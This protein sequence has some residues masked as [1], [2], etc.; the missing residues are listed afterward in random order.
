M[1]S[2]PFLKSIGMQ[3]NTKPAQLNTRF[4]K[5]LS[6]EQQERVE[7]IWERSSMGFGSNTELYSVPE[8][9][10]QAVRLYSLDA[11]RYAVSLDWFWEVTAHTRPERI[12]EIGAGAGITSGYLKKRQEFLEIAG[13]EQHQ[14]LARI[15]GN[16]FGGDI[17]VGDYLEVEGD[18][19]HDL[20]ICDFG[21]D[22]EDLPPSQ[23]PHSTA[24]IGGF[25]YC[26][27]CT[28]DLSETLKPYF[29]KWS[30]WMKETGKFAVA[31][32]FYHVGM[33]YAALVAAQAAGLRPIEGLCDVLKTT[34][35]GTK[36]K[37]PAMV[38]ERGEMQASLDAAAYLYSL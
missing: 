12:F 23:K 30:S 31:G 33:V 6:G 24:E 22:I 38:F 28:E 2:K 10:K 35:G 34:E 5:S 13:I 1:T 18:G 20:V 29:E 7:D 26:P 21:F 9:M 27:G 19:S 25:E 3:F 4:Y 32:R 14:N 36:Q 37:Y 16:T 15:A 8:T 11:A 17:R